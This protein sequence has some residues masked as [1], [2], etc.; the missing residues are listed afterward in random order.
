MSLI[1]SI[2]SLVLGLV[3]LGLAVWLRLGRHYLAREWADQ[4]GN[5][6]S[7]VL[8]M[9]P[10]AGVA[11]LAVGSLRWCEDPP[12]DMLCLMTLFVGM[13]L[14][15]WGGFFDVPLWA[16]PRWARDLVSKR[17]QQTRGTWKG[18]A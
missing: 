9:L 18:S 4:F 7:H 3:L 16:V 10:G 5:T 8:L 14:V 13:F 2:V 15:L 12:L 11:A 17:R 6:P 1:W